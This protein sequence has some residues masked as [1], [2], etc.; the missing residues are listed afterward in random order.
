[1]LYA[2][3]LIVLHSKGAHATASANSRVTDVPQRCLSQRS[4][5]VCRNPVAAIV[6]TPLRQLP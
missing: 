4:Y 1:M 2:S 5:C 3:S 6:V